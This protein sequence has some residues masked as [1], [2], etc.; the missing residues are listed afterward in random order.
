[1]RILV[2]FCC[3]LLLVVLMSI[4]RLDHHKIIR[5]LF[6]MSSVFFFQ[7]NRQVGQG[8]S[9]IPIYPKTNIQYTQKQ[10]K[11]H[12]QYQNLKNYDIIYTQN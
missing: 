7:F 12:V 5:F 8:G 3:L 10:F 4:L 1:M 2:S 6:S 11:I 9:G